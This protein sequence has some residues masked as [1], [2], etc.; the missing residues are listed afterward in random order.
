MWLIYR[1]PSFS[2]SRDN[3]FEK[4]TRMWFPRCSFRLHS[5]SHI[6][7][8]NDNLVRELIDHAGRCSYRSERIGIARTA[9]LF[10]SN[11]SC[12][13]LPFTLL[14]QSHS[15]CNCIQ[16]W[17]HLVAS[18]C[19]N[20]WSS[21]SATSEGV[22]PCLFGPLNVATS[23]WIFRSVGPDVTYGGSELQWGSHSWS[24][25]TPSPSELS[26]TYVVSSRKDEIICWLNS[27]RILQWFLSSRRL[28][29]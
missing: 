9:H 15:N 4:T 14:W 11:P 5:A 6:F 24:F 27:W 17:S 18:L 2:I 25:I 21:M 29:S 12:S 23:N 3:F 7:F 19:I 13:C 26:F 20:G 8:E 1:H 10:H 16:T 22:I 28:L